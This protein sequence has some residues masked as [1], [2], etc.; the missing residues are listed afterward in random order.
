MEE[1]APIAIRMMANL[2]SRFGIF[3]T[4]K[5][6]AEMVPILG[7]LGGAAINLLFIRHFQATARGHFTV[8]RLERKYGGELIKKEYER[9]LKELRNEIKG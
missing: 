8:R 4:D 5:M 7:G 6:A 2:A 1:G 9:A 3:V